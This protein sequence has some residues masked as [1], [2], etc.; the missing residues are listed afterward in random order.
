MNASIFVVL[1]GAVLLFMPG[2]AW[3]GL[4]FM[5]IGLV[6]YYFAQS[7]PSYYGQA[8]PLAG[9]APQRLRSSFQPSGV[10]V[11]SKSALQSMDD[12]PRQPF[13]DNGM[14]NLPVPIDEDV[15]R[16]VN[17][18]YRTKTKAKGYAE[19]MDKGGN[20]WLPGFDD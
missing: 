1:F 10:A 6:A 16:F 5:G 13:I 17:V 8:Y 12:A 11:T 18:N 4:A 14:F 15:G 9:I 20:P 19:S 2:G 3:A 7:G